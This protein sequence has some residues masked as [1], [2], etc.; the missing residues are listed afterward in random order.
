ML[1]FLVI[2]SNFSQIAFIVSFHF[3]KENLGIYVFYVVALG[4]QILI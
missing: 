3:I 1:T 4:N 2:I